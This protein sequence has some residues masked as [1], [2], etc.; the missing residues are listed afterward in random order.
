MQVST[1]APNAPTPT[2][3]ASSPPAAKSP[4]TKNPKP[5]AAPAQKRRASKAVAPNQTN[6]PTPTD[7]APTPSSSGG[8]SVKRQ[9]EE[10]SMFNEVVTPGAG[11]V[12]H[13]PSPPKRAKTEWEEQ[14]SEEMKI[15]QEAVDNV[16]TEEDA[17]QFLEQMTE[18]IK[19]VAENEGQD[20]SLPSNIA[21]TLDMFLKGYG[22]VPNGADLGGLGFGDASGREQ[23]PMPDPIF[24]QFIDFSFGALDDDDSKAPTPDLLSSSSTNT[25]P[26]SN[27]EDP[28]HH[29][30]SAAAALADAH[31]DDT[32]DLLRLGPWKDIDGGEAPYYQ[33]NEWKWDSP[34]PTS[35]QAWAIFN[36]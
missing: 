7:Q 8:V 21:D 15:K 31:R 1:P 17:S 19:H 18:L 9:R 5:K 29:T 24:E 23:S 6:A 35:D 26:E 2:A 28:S 20:S 30:L 4:K 22:A 11:G 27:H 36:T 12:A 32:A 16:K 33:S 10:D 3:T 34:M 25:S 14:P 13:E